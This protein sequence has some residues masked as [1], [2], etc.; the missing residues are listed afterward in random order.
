MVAATQVERQGSR[1]R[2]PFE[3]LSEDHTAAAAA[4]ALFQRT[5]LG[6]QKDSPPSPH[7]CLES[8][9]NTRHFYLGVGI[10]NDKR[11]ARF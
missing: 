2:K 10:F 8:V 5:K 6:L 7:L 4:L 11:K 9:D 3:F 1:G